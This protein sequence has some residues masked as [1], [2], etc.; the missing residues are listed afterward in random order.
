MVRAVLDRP[1]SHMLRP[2][3]VALDRRPIEQADRRFDDEPGSTGKAVAHRS[4]IE[5]LPALVNV[6]D[7]IRNRHRDRRVERHPSCEPRVE[8]FPMLVGV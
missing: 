7:L 3:H 1:V 2:H 6:V 8:A 5:E 4:G